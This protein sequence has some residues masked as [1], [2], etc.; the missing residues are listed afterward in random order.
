MILLLEN[1]CVLAFFASFAFAAALAGLV[2]GL[3][4]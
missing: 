4:P 2:E 3:V 1:T